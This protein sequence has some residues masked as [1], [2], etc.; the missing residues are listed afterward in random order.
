M[1][2]TIWAVTQMYHPET[3]LTIQDPLS[4]QFKHYSGCLLPPLS[5]V[6]LNASSA[7]VLFQKIHVYLTILL[8]YSRKQHGWS[9]FAPKYLNENK[10]LSL[11]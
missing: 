9:L 8:L 10:I 7:T 6:K 1:T 2:A 11:H 3:P 4:N 5:S